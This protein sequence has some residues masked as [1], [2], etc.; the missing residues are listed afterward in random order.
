MRKIEQREQ[1][2]EEHAIGNF[3]ANHVKEVSGKEEIMNV[4][5]YE[6]EEKD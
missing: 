3:Y 4:F 2:K 5:E 1:R 6:Y